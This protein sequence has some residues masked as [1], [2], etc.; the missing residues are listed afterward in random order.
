MRWRLPQVKFIPAA[1]SYYLLAAGGAIATLAAV[2]LPQQIAMAIGF[3]ASIIWFVVVVIAT[4]V[5]ARQTQKVTVTRQ[6]IDRLSIGRENPLSVAI[7]NTQ[8]AT[9]RIRDHIPDN[10]IVEP[11]Y[12]SANLP[13]VGKKPSPTI[14]SYQVRPQ[15]RGEFTF[16]D[17]SIRQLSRRKLAWLTWEEKATTT[18]AVYPDLIYL[19]SLSIKLALQAAGAMRQRRQIGGGTEFSELREYGIGDDPRFIDWKA[20]ARRDRPLVRVLEP[21]KEQTAIILL[22]RGRLMTAKVGEMTRF[23]YGLNATLSLALAATKRG[24]RVGVGV[25]DR[26][27]HVWI[28]PQRGE[29]HFAKIVDRLSRIEPELIEPDYQEAV[30]QIISQQSR[31][32][33]VVT[34]TEIVDPIASSE[35]L[36]AVSRLTPRYLPFCVALRDPVLDSIANTRT[37]A[38]P[39]AYERAVALDSIQERALVFKQLQQKGVLVLDAPVNSL[40]DDLVDRYLQIKQRAQL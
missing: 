28:P 8:A 21:E 31:R 17:I 19:R 36:T 29:S 38:V 4:W 16:G 1:R 40:A 20:T 9:L 18:V 7:V 34:I 27:L 39:A 13:A 12:L 22:D 32:A 25:F 33:L 10:F 37:I 3:F 5:D 23:D 14:L 2:I 6:E 26:N 24:D 35:L 30:S 11:D 15:Q